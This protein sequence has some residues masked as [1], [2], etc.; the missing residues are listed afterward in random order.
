MSLGQ[1]KESGGSNIGVQDYSLSFVV[2]NHEPAM[3][4]TVREAV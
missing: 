1:H 4:R 3:E 2:L